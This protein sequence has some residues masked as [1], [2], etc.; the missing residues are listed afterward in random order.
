MVASGQTSVV[1]TTSMARWVRRGWPRAAARRTSHPTVTGLGSMDSSGAAARQRSCDTACPCARLPA[2]AIRTAARASRCPWAP[3]R[4]STRGRSL[5][6]SLGETGRPA[7]ERHDLR[8]PLAPADALARPP[9]PTR[10]ALLTMAVRHR[11]PRVAAAPPP[12]MLGPDA[13]RWGGSGDRGARTSTGRAAIASPRPRGLGWRRSPPRVGVGWGEGSAMEDRTHDHGGH[14]S[15]DH[16]GNDGH[17]PETFR[18]RFWVSLVLTL[19][20]LYFS[21]Q[22]RTWLRYEAVGFPGSDWVNPVLGT[23][24][25]VYGGVVFLRGARHELAAKRPGMM[26]LIS[27][28]IVVAYVYSMA[29]VLGAPG[30]PFFWEL[31]T[32]L[33]IMV[34]GHWLEMASV[35]GASRALEELTRLLP[36]VAHRLTA[37]GA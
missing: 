2:K 20:I 5:R 35:R 15:H 24:L 19:P 17:D 26:T 30:M 29:V 11:P 27:L 16:S 32:L 22:F 31:A 25:F 23:V 7:P 12:T 18:R 1:K 9:V 10:A 4:T 33:T 8:T 34:L 14:V 37:T 36:V 21:E 6:R 3:G 13:G 28:A